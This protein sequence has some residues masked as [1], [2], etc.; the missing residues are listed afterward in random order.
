MSAIYDGPASPHF[1]P[2][3]FKGNANAPAYV[4]V[5]GEISAALNAAPSGGCVSLGHPVR[6]RRGRDRVRPAGFH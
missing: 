3:P 2:L 6:D 5:S 1:R 4:G